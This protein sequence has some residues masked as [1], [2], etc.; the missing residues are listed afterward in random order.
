[1]EYV[2]LAS[3]IVLALRALWLYLRN[4]VGA[5]EGSAERYRVMRTMQRM[6]HGGDA[7]RQAAALAFLAFF[8]WAAARASAPDVLPPTG[9]PE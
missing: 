1:M 2:A 8:V 5:A 9:A 7:Y 3:T 4:F 6:A